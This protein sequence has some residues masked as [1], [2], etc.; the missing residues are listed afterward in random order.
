MD[1]ARHVFSTYFGDTT[2]PLVR[3]HLDSF[4]DLLTTKIP[5]FIK[6]SNPQRILIDER[7]VDVYIGG[8]NNK[9]TYHPPTEG[10]EEK[11]TVLPHS[12]RL[13]NKTYALEI[14]ADIDIE[15]TIGT[16]TTKSFENVLIGKIPLMLKSSLCSLSSM[17][18][19][20][21]KEAGECSFELGGYFIIS[22][23]EKVLLSQ[24]RLGDNI[25]YATKRILPASSAQKRGLTEKES[26]SKIENATKEDKFEYIA[27]IRSISE[28]GTNGPYSHF[29]IIPPAN[30]KPNDPKVIDKISDYA[31]FST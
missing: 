7:I 14:R 2:N 12:C 31:V 17:T 10:D 28:D 8:K 23:A 21:L 1:V 13:E 16:T 19:S 18:S 22:G 11:L 20:E 24:E 26:E 15:Y 4:S 25:P 6:G 9:I 5:N 29:L 30:Q 27:G 3:H